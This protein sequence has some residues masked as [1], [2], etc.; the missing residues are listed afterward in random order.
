MEDLAALLTTCTLCAAG[1]PVCIGVCI[2]DEAAHARALAV[3]RK[4]LRPGAHRTF[5]YG[6]CGQCAVLDKQLVATLVEARLFAS[7]T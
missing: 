3:T 2:P 5:V 7:R 6:L 1:R 4:R